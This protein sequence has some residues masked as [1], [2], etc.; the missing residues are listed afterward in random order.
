[1]MAPTASQA[2]FLIINDTIWA[3]PYI[4]ISVGDF[5]GG[6]SVNGNQIQQGIGTTA[7]ATID[8]AL[9][10]IT[11]HGSW[12]DLGASGS[13]TRTIYM[14]EEGTLNLV[15]DILRISWSS[16]GTSA[17]IDGTF[18]SEVNDEVGLGLV[19]TELG[20]NDIVTGE[21]V[22]FSLPYLSAMANSIPEPS[23]AV[24]PLLGA[25]LF[26]LRRRRRG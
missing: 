25:G 21:V 8:E 6:F 2:A 24:L 16:D 7:S 22:D 23:Q 1:M 5:E 17:V 4:N 3:D 18:Q 12:M 11:F 9:G 15:S 10:E 26:A 14:I 19:P 20:P 13:G